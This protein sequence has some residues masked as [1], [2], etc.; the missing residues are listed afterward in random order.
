V[1]FYKSFSI[2]KATSCTIL[3]GFLLLPEGGGIKFPMI[4]QFDKVAIPSICAF[5]GCLLASKRGLRF[6][7]RLGLIEVLIVIYLIGPFI[8]SALNGDDIVVGGRVL[9]GVDAYDGFSAFEGRFLFFVPFVLGRQFFRDASDIEEVLNILV[10]AGI[11][12]SFLMLFEIR[13]S[14]QLSLWIYGF[15]PSTYA[16]ETRSGGFRPVVFL[17]NGLIVSF[18]AMTCTVAASA[19]WSAR[20]KIFRF[21]SGLVTLYLGF[22]LLL[23]KSAGALIYGCISVFF[24]R[25]FS[26]RRQLQFAV[27]L[28]GLSILYPFLRVEGL[29]PDDSLVEISAL[30]SRERADSLNFRFVQEDN[31]LARASER[32]TFGWGRFGRSRLFDAEN[33]LDQSVTDGRWIVTI[34]TFGIFGFIAEFGLLAFPI[35]YAYG[36]F[37]CITTKREEVLFSALALIVALSV[38]EQLPNSSISPWTW[39]LV[40]SL[41][42]RSEQLRSRTAKFQRE[43][44]VVGR[45]ERVQH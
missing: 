4:P 26:T 31:L 10:V 11:C 9:P 33:G 40:G 20:I 15:L 29:F 5:V 27:A 30:V 43:Q 37:N 17:G 35:F 23:C 7:A 22:V 44:R 45:L 3:G 1:A 6:G 13:M 39:L 24:V 16:V 38:I 32:F 34:G 42:G 14:P 41:L 18:F 12:Y 28:A 8:T 36:T 19:F 21:N 25:F 2:V